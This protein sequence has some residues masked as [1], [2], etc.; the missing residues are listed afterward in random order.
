MTAPV[1]PRRKPAARPRVAGAVSYIV[2]S[3]GLI[4]TLLP[5]VWTL[6]GA[7]KPEAELVANLSGWLPQ[8]PTVANFAE[9][10]SSMDFLRAA[11]NSVVVVVVTMFTNVVLC[12]LFAYALTKIEFRGRNLLFGAVVGSIMIPTIATFVPTFIVVANLRLVNTLFGIAV[13]FLVASVCVFIMRQYMLSVPDELIEAARI[14]GASELRIFARIV[15]PLC[16]PAVVTM[17][18]ITGLANWNSFLW[19]LVVAQDAAYY[20][21][22]VALAAQSQGAHQT[23]YGALLAG[24]LVVMA[25]VLIVFLVLQR[26]FIQGVAT[27]GL[28]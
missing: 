21:L 15:L 6:L 24:S 7:F 26:Y 20:T 2:L 18:I 22:P 19:P 16:T 17:L 23:D 5:F 3:L 28:K 14:D 8:N 12:S 10:F 1:L 27:E 4:V 13:P 9:L 11:F 25:P